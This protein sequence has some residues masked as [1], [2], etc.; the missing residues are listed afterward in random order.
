MLMFMMLLDT[1]EEK[2]LFE[3]L[4]R[5]HRQSMYALAYSILE[6]EEAS[7]DVVHTVFVRITGKMETLQKL[8]ENA[9]KNYLLSAVKHVAVDI[10]RKRKRHPVIS[11]EEVPEEILAVYDIPDE[12]K[13]I[14]KEILNLPDTYR[15]ILQYKYVYECD[16]KEIA[17]VLGIKEATIRKRLER[18]RDL[19]RKRLGHV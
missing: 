4:Y 6:Q 2:S 13:A 9:R 1:E 8:G 12:G 18:A 15:E 7:E 14:I 10:K 5:E 16:N 17:N 19:L 3:I 11:I